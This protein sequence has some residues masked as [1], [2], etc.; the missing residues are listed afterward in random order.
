LRRWLSAD[1]REDPTRANWKHNFV[2]EMDEIQA[3]AE[4]LGVRFLYD[5]TEFSGSRADY[6]FHSTGWGIVPCINCLYGTMILNS[7][8]PNGL[9]EDALKAVVT[10]P[11]GERK[12][13]MPCGECRDRAIRDEWRK[14]TF[15]NKYPR[16][17]DWC[18]LAW[19]FDR[20]TL[21]SVMVDGCQDFPSFGNCRRCGQA[22]II[23]AKCVACDDVRK[24]YITRSGCIINPYLI[25]GICGLRGDDVFI[26]SE[27]EVAAAEEVGGDVQDLTVVFEPLTVA[28]LQLD[29]PYLELNEREKQIITRLVHDLPDDHWQFTGWSGLATNFPMNRFPSDWVTGPSPSWDLEVDWN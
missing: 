16:L 4:A 13:I 28:Q 1:L 12:T 21:C 20:Q 14:E 17:I 19:E 24:V 10:K 11:G 29:F 15:P 27:E 3:R 23:D 6:Y 2:V 7:A 26:H 8:S 9:S 22:G 5:E 18:E 25:A